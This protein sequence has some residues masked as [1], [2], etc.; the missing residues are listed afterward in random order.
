MYWPLERKFF[1]GVV[2]AF[3]ART[4]MHHIDYDDGDQEE[5]ILAT[6]DGASA[7][8]DDDFMEHPAESPATNTGSDLPALDAPVD[9]SVSLVVPQPGKAGH[10][11]NAPCELAHRLVSR[12]GTGAR[13]TAGGRARYARRMAI[14]TFRRLLSSTTVS[15]DSIVTICFLSS[16]TTARCATKKTQG[17]AAAISRPPYTIRDDSDRSVVEQKRKSRPERRTQRVKLR[18][19][20]I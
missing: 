7:R 2:T 18:E 11:Q 13:D 16:N 17:Y 12:L 14:T 19:S 9:Q 1:A 20:G 6:P 10:S 5:I 3:N 15:R 4:G 8:K